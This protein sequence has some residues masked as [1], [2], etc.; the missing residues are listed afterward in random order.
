MKLK[1]GK[2]STI[3]AYDLSQSEIYNILKVQINMQFIFVSSHDNETALA[4]IYLLERTVNGG[5][6]QINIQ[7]GNKK[8]T[9]TYGKLIETMKEY[10][11]LGV[12]TMVFDSKFFKKKLPII[13]IVGDI[14]PEII[15]GC[16][17]L[18]YDDGM[19]SIINK[20][21]NNLPNSMYF[22][23]ETGSLFIFGTKGPKL[24]YKTKYSDVEEIICV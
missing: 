2:N 19:F 17:S 9:I 5:V 11:K 18:D 7:I 6:Q 3:I 23:E 4:N 16:V 12:P 20:E 8:E 22:W 1:N 14:K 21:Q 13:E 10:F 24:L 15:E